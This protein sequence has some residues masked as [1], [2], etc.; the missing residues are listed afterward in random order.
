MAPDWALDIAIAPDG[1]LQ[2]IK[3]AI[4]RPKKRAFGIL[5]IEKEFVGFIR[6][7][8]FEVWE[9]HQRAVHALG[10]VRGRRGGSRIE[11]RFA[12]PGRTRVLIAVFFVVY[13]GAVAGLAFRTAG[14]LGTA[15]ELVV[16]SLGA[17]LLATIF[18]LA[19]A[20]QRSD[21]RGFFDRL[22][23]DLPRI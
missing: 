1:A 2:Q 6:D 21:L 12:M 7:D 15:E 14:P 5:K 10:S 20:R 22:F 3:A 4:N 11:L 9:R 13:A 16:A 8:S 18:T 23:R 17:L 19:R